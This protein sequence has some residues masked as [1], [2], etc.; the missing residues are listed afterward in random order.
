MAPIHERAAAIEASIEPIQV[1]LDEV[2][3]AMAPALDE[4]KRLTAG[5]DEAV[6]GEI[7]M[8]LR[9]HV[10]PACGDHAPYAAAADEIAD[11]ASIHVFD[12][13]L[14]VDAPLAT[15]RSIL[16][17]VLEPRRATD[18]DSFDTAVQRAAAEP[19]RLRLRVNLRN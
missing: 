12:D 5:V 7:A 11:A 9:E 16:D 17:E 18:R 1:D 19:S 10:A 2:R 13:G 14:Q 4:I 6:R 15:V 8:A 3:T